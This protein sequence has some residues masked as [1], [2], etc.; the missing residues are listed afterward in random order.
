MSVN[1]TSTTSSAAIPTASNE[2]SCNPNEVMGPPGKMS[3]VTTLAPCN[4]YK[5]YGLIAVLLL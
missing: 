3:C 1:M 4:N 2:Q 5:H